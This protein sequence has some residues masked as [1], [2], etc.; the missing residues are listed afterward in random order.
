MI[1]AMRDEVIVRP[2]YQDNVGKIVIP[3]GS[4]FGKN[5]GHGQFRLYDGFIYGIVESVGPRYKET[6]NG[7]PLRPGHKVIWR[8]HEGKRLLYQ[9]QE[10]LGAAIVA[11]RIT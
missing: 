2:V 11:E 9:G 8:R 10:F 5:T 6:F 4:T 3:E 7:Q 1:Q